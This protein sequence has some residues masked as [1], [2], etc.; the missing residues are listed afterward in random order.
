MLS[1]LIGNISA[2]GNIVLIYN[3]ILVLQ[4]V[5][6]LKT[7]PQLCILHIRNP[8][9]VAITDQIMPKFIS[10]I[11]ALKHISFQGFCPFNLRVNA[12]TQTL[13]CNNKIWNRSFHERGTGSGCFIFADNFQ[14][15]SDHI[16]IIDFRL[17]FIDGIEEC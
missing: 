2:F 11:Q 8:I 3:A 9:I 15:P 6:L 5:P 1:N 12:F 13:K 7:F 10:I 17:N 14:G 16:Q 4:Q